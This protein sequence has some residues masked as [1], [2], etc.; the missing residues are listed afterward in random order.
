MKTYAVIL[1]AG[2]GERFASDTP[3]QFLK[4]SG[5]TV[6]EHS[7][8]A[9]EHNDGIDEIIIVAHKDFLETCKNIVEKAGFKKV[10]NIVTGGSTRKESSSIGVNQIQ[11]KEAKVLIHDS[12]RPLVSDEIISKCISE[13]DIHDA[14]DVAVHT[15]DTIIKTNIDGT[16]CEIPD[17]QN[18][19]SGQT[20][21]CFKLSLIKRAHQL[22]KLVDMPFTDDCGIVNH[23]KL[24]KVHVLYGSE[25]NIKITYPI[26]IFIADKLFQI[27]K[28]NKPQDNLKNISG[29]VLI[30]IGASSGIGQSIANIAESEGAIVHGFSRENGVDVREKSTL[31]A[32]FRDVFRKDGRIDFIIN[33]AGL[34]NIKLLKEK[35]DAEI[36][37]EISTNYIGCINVA[38]AAYHYLKLSHGGLLFFSSSSYT[39]GREMYSIY[40]STKAA[41]VNFV[42]AISD[43]WA[44]DGIRINV[45][46]P[47][48]TMTPMRLKAFGKEPVGTLLSPEIVAKKSISTILQDYTGQ[49]V[50]VRLSIDS[51]IPDQVHM[52]NK[53]PQKITI[54]PDG[55]KIAQ[56]EIVGSNM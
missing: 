3:K 25:S 17:R 27:R 47:Q 1:A 34:L 50:D 20:P 30:V 29:K 51:N 49:V 16:I 32:A 14:I 11:E 35:T 48:R 36:F 23:F 9:F 28:E 41:V 13:L 26:D 44:Y 55:A 43:E 15:T 42:Q 45:I 2:S 18:L 54:T 31:D 38:K 37:D 39:R 21:Q 24:A 46:N 4:I 56:E 5:E 19:M 22:A 52:T 33:S 6:F 53:P 12:V 10:T 40:S 7:V 8:S